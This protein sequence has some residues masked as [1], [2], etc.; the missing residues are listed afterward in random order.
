[1]ARKYDNQ[2]RALATFTTDSRST[3]NKRKK[4]IKAADKAAK[5]KASPRKQGLLTDL[6]EKRNMTY[7][8]VKGTMKGK[9]VN[10]T[11]SMF[12]AKV[13]SEVKSKPANIKKATIYKPNPQAVPGRKAITETRTGPGR[14]TSVPKTGKLKGILSN[15]SDGPNQKVLRGQFKE[16]LSKIVSQDSK[17]NKSNAPR[18]EFNKKKKS[19]KR[20]HY[21][22]MMAKKLMGG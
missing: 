1:M 6:Q 13:N 22:T 2:G 16:N 17:P 18:P 9:P 10:T 15:Y 3:I 4:G 11:G 19:T 7:Q 8:S 12:K 14:V 20:V 5:T 21:A